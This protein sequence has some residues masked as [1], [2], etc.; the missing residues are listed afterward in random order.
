MLG[1]KVWKKIVQPDTI[2]EARPIS[3]H[4][5]RD[6]DR[7]RHQKRTESEGRRETPHPPPR[8]AVLPDREA[9]SEQ[10]SEDEIRQQQTRFQ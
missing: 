6:R 3:R 1:V 2:I 7:P 8:S 10:R 5:E 9:E 4:G